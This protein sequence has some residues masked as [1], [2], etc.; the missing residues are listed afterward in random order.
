LRY[1]RRYMYKLPK[2]C[3]EV[4]LIEDNTLI[5]L[6]LESEFSKFGLRTDKATDGQSGWTACQEKHYDLI[7]IDLQLPLI[8][9]KELIRK[10][11][12]ELN[13]TQGVIYAMAAGLSKAEIE[14]LI[15]LG[16]DGYLQKPVTLTPKGDQLILGASPQ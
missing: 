2:N 6:V 7:L 13:E 9:G 16:Y 1:Y 12:N 10:I 14:E 8:N 11:R 3:K 5:L 15:H 4:L